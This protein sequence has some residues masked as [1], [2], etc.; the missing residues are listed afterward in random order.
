MT[1][2]HTLATLSAMSRQDFVAALGDLY[3]HSPWV[4]DGAW[5][6]QPFDSVEAL[7]AALSRSMRSATPEQQMTLIRAHPELAGRAAVRDELTADSTAEQNSAGLNQC[8]PE[9][10]AQIQQ[11]NAAWQHKF[12]FPFVIAVRGLDRAAIITQMKRRLASDIKT[13]FAEALDQIDRIAA[14]R[15]AQRLAPA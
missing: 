1:A 7:Q 13:E 11:L 9:E 15:L 3:E 8:S 14:L 5:L 10:F 4:A 6:A 12:G 2:I